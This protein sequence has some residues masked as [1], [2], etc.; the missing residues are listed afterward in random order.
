M[1]NLNPLFVQVPCLQDYF[2]DKDTAQAM[3]GGI[4]TFYSAENHTVL[5]PVYQISAGPGPTYQYNALANPLILSSIGTFVDE[6]GNDIIPYFYP[7][8]GTPSSN[9][10]VPE[11]ELYYITVY[12][13]QGVFQF[14]RDGVPN[15]AVDSS[16]D[17]APTS[18]NLLS[19][20][21]F[22]TV[23][24]SPLET[25]TLSVSGTNTISPIAPDWDI[26][27]TGTGTVTIIQ[28]PVS[29]NLPIPSNPP[30]LLDIVATGGAL[31]SPIYLRQT[32][33]N[34]PTLLQNG[35]ASGYFVARSLDG[36]AHQLI[37]TY[38]N[39]AASYELIND[40][41]TATGFKE[42][43]S[44]PA[45]PINGAFD[46]T[47]SNNGYVTLT[48]QIPLN[49]HIQISSIQ[50][51]SVS[52]QNATPE[53]IPISP[54][55]QKDHVF[56]YHYDDILVRPKS[57][58]LTGWYFSLNPYQLPFPQDSNGDY[59]PTV[60]EYIADQT[61]LIQQNI[62]KNNTGSN[63]KKGLTTN[64]NLK[65]TALTAH[66]QFALVQYIDPKTTYGYW[67]YFMSA[68]GRLRLN[69]TNGTSVRYKIR[70]FGMLIYRIL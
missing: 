9:P 36:L 3:A 12:S 53:F 21:Q 51:V 19:N 4:V 61:I 68:L 70:L 43:I 58:I 65:I 7:Y 40:L 32:L 52:N 37:M 13:A 46:T 34:C 67:G 55:R 63:V 60:N 5:K 69:S 26:I 38:A 49:A 8:Q 27:T 10:Q 20:S 57:S 44:T 35:I 14:S 64:A 50:L 62:V 17:D 59:T 28:A 6:N 41:T 22:T 47:N 33:E 1:P 2:V 29:G 15:I 25:L 56:H 18:Q 16:L 66:N 42:F 39:Q 45:V 11:I 30:Y 31:S 24:F 48:I 23:S 54:E